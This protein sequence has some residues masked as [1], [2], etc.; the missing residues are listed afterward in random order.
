MNTVALIPLRGG[1]KGIPRKNLRPIAGKPLFQWTLEAAVK[2]P[3][4]D[5]VFVSTDDPDI[6]REVELLH[7]DKVE[8]IDRSPA[9]ATD[10]ASTESVMLEFAQKQVAE[11]IIL[12]QATSPLLEATDL[13]GGIRE[14]DS[15]NADTLLSVVAQKRFIWKRNGN[16]LAVPVNYQPS[17]R[18][19]R[20]DFNPYYVENG[21]F[22]ICTR[23][24]LLESQCRVFGKVALYKMPEESYYELDEP[25]DW[26]IIEGL[27]N[28]HRWH[29][30]LPVDQP[31]NRD[32]RALRERA[33]SIKLVITDVDGVLTDSGMYYSESG[34]ELKKFNTRDGKA[35][36]LLRNAGI[37]TGIIT[38]EST[39]I[40]E[41]RARKMK[42][43]YLE[44]GATSK[45]PA[46]ERVIAAAGIKIE[47]VAYIGDDLGDLPVMERVGISACPADAVN[48]VSHVAHFR[49]GS[50]G[51]R[52][53]LREFV[54]C[55]FVGISI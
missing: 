15:Q 10:T 30:A 29:P 45:L 38:S 13:S 50:C 11:R 51:G 35:F 23:Q 41:W 6:R 7:L 9:T 8:V 52:G 26:R 31:A 53:C 24:G 20:Q 1:S 43:D 39:A 12:I 19:R 36:E 37:K 5:L 4:I 34:E 46:L 16:G 18:P 32:L 40:V 27:L 2:T 21:A 33:K 42:I 17:A 28:A 22:Y 48:A 55:L 47:E 49:C 44:Q 54:E 25:A 3:E 14:F